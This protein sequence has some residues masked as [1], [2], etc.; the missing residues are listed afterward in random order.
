MKRGVGI[1]KANVSCKKEGRG[2]DKK[3]Q[4]KSIYKPNQLGPSLSFGSQIQKSTGGSC[5]C[6]LLKLGREVILPFFNAIHKV[7]G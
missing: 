6:L 7:S 5:V 1:H 3:N 4:L 2:M